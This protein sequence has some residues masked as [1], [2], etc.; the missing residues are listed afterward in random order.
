MRLSCKSFTKSR[1]RS[2]KRKKRN[3]RE[4]RKKKERREKRKKENVSSSYSNSRTA[5][6]TLHL[7]TA[8]ERPQTAVS[9]PPTTAITTIPTRA[10]SHGLCRVIIIFP[11][12]SAGVGVLITRVSIFGHRE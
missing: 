1:K 3:E 5:T 12:A 6:A 11:T 9:L 10:S 2:R 8:A 7:Q 4:K